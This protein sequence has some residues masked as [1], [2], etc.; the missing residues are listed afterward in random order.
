M[1]METEVKPKEPRG[2]GNPWKRETIQTAM[3]SAYN[4]LCLSIFGFL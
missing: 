3:I 1:S 2:G 4:D